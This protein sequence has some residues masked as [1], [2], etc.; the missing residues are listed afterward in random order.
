MADKVVE[1]ANEVHDAIENRTQ[2]IEELADLEEILL[3]LREK[4]GI[5]VEEIEV[6]R[7]KKLKERWGF[8]KHLFLSWIEE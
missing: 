6:I 1:E 8:E 5:S 2:L 7:L 3:A 4:S